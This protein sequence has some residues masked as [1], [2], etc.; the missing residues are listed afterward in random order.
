MEKIRLAGRD[1]DG[2]R[3][4]AGRR[5]DADSGRDECGRHDGI[6][7]YAADFIVTA[8]SLLHHRYRRMM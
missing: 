7:R 6:S 2:Q 4:G 8:S 5:V 1:M 3:V